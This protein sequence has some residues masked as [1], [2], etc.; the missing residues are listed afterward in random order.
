MTQQQPFM[1]QPNPD[2]DGND[3]G[4]MAISKQI[5]GPPS[6]FADYSQYQLTPEFWYFVK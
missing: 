5:S 6:D 2:W 1:F 4:I 3:A